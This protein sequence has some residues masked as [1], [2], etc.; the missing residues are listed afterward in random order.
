[1]PFLNALHVRNVPAPPAFKP[2]RKSPEEPP[3]RV[4]FSKHPGQQREQSRSRTRTLCID[5]ATPTCRAPTTWSP[6]E[7]I[8]P[9][10]QETER[11]CR[12]ARTTRCSRPGRSKQGT[13]KEKRSKT[14]RPRS[15]I[16]VSTP[17]HSTQKIGKNGPTQTGN[18]NKFASG[19]KANRR[20]H[21]G[22][23]SPWRCQCWPRAPPHPEF[24]C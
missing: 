12:A 17:N 1:M 8:R 18:G 20:S 16:S 10:T 15:R 6:D 7:S 23:C 4:A 21:G 22:S 3:R 11:E 19:M 14:D 24:Q 9:L 13:D 5:L 2:R